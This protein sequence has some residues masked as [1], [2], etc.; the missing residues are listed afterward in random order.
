MSCAYEIINKSLH[1]IY[2]Y[3]CFLSARA[4]DNNEERVIIYHHVMYISCDQLEQHHQHNI[5]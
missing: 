4:S 1:V 5:T 3:N 2:T